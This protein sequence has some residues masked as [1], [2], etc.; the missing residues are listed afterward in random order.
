MIAGGGGEGLSQKAGHK[1]VHPGGDRSWTS[2]QDSQEI[3]R[4]ERLKKVCA[5]EPCSGLE[6]RGDQRGRNFSKEGTQGETI[7]KRSVLRRKK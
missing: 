3:R 5:G 7:A 2:V 4:K 6:T 1:F